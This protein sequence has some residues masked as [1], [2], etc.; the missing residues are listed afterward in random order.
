MPA[1]EFAHLGMEHVAYVK[2]VVTN[3]EVSYAIHAADGTPMGTAGSRDAAIA[4]VRQHGFD[5]MSVH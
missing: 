1:P 4:A 2:R 3:G 5:A